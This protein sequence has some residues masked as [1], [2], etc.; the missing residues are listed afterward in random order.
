MKDFKDFLSE[1]GAL[2]TDGLIEFLEDMPE[3]LEDLSNFKRHRL[4]K[5]I[6]QIFK[7]IRLS[8]YE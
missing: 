4:E 5:D 2:D 6:E 1:S 3:D 7:S 8:Y